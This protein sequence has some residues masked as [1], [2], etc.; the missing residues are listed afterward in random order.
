MKRNLV[1]VAILVVVLALSLV[2]C[3]THVHTF[4]QD[5]E[6]D[7]NNHWHKA[8]CEHS[9]EK[10]DLAPHSFDSNGKC[11]CGKTIDPDDLPNHVHVYTNMWM[12]DTTNHWHGAKCKHYTQ[13]TE[14]EQH[15]F[16][17][18]VCSVCGAWEDFSTTFVNVLSQA[19]V[20]NYY[21]T[22]EN[23]DLGDM[24]GD[25]SNFLVNSGELKLSIN[26]DGE[27]SG[28]GSLFVTI[29]PNEAG[30]NKT[31]QASMKCVVEDGVLYAIATETGEEDVYFKTTLQSLLA[32]SGTDVVSEMQQAFAQ[33][34]FSLDEVYDYLNQAKYY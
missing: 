24:S 6:G 17:D 26:K 29:T 21:W 34:D 30:E 15:T 13:Q 25:G 11:V 12:F 16:V 3:Q 32:A 14:K 23:F 28:N 4:S 31:A 1:L 2:A 5:W 22:V 7:D 27:I 19:E 18:G 9:D 10:G 20:W 8:T 33:I